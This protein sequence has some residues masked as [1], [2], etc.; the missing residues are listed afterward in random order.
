MKHLFFIF[1]IIVFI[2]ACDP[3]HPDM[4]EGHDHAGEEVHQI[5]LYTDQ[6]EFFI[7]Y[8]A[9]LLQSEAVFTVHLT[10]LE[11]YKPYP[12]GTV[13]ITLGSHKGTA[14]G[15]SQIQEGS[16]SV[17][18]SPGIFL[19]RLTPEIPGACTI[20]FEFTADGTTERVAYTHGWVAEGPHE[21]E[22]GHERIPD[23]IRFTKEQ[24]WKSDF[25]V[26]RLVPATFTGIIKAGGEI[27]AMPGEKHFI[28]ARSTGI[29][30]YSR[31]DLVA[32]ADIAR[33][34]ELMTIQGQDLARENIAVEY[35]EAEARFMQSRSE[36]E[37]STKLF[38]NNAISEKHFIETR[39]D[40][41]TD[42]IQY[43]NLKKSYDEGGMKILSP[44]AGYI[45]KLNVSQ[46]E[47]V[48]AGQLIATVSSDR[49][50]LLRADVP[51][52][53]FN[54]IHEIVSTNFRTSYHRNVWDIRDF[55]GK[56]IAIGSSAAENNQY[57]PVYFEA[58]NNGQ[59]MEGAFAEFFLKTRVVDSCLV[60]PLEALIEEQGKF[61]VYVQMAGEIFRK[62]EIVPG[63][64]DGFVARVD[65]GLAEG[66]RLVTRGSMLLKTASMTAS[67]PGDAHQH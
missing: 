40:Y 57:L 25:M 46:G 39:S 23:G 20:T 14:G 3:H 13:R 4:E 63:Y 44:I 8:P 19:V 43:Y 33:G 64:T 45:H 38:R 51:Q 60:V 66:D 5:T 15:S 7:E 18:E 11:N 2:T 34:E 35:A 47:F 10:R 24:A 17:A 30:N 53:Y 29:V 62:Q 49:R 54:R 65:S 6:S 26:T 9:L 1:P 21:T 61:Y 31:L 37:R 32:G 27:L 59:L 52:Q 48:R 28:H 50:L 67:L 36:Y 41:L 16:V 42:S 55:A 22:T 12:A 56:L 58:L